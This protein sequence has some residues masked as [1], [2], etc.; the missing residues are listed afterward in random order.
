[1]FVL[2]KSDKKEKNPDVGHVGIPRCYH[3][4]ILT[5]S[6]AKVGIIFEL[7]KFFS[8]KIAKRRK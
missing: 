6:S 7:D 2:R 8:K 1:M 4:F 3:V 5:Y